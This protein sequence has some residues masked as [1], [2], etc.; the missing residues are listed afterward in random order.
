MAKG[1]ATAFDE[2]QLDANKAVHNLSTAVIKVGFVD[3]TI[4]PAADDPTP[5]WADYS[6][7]EVSTDGGYPA[8]GVILATVTF[9]LINGVP[10]LKADDVEL[11]MDPAGFT[12]AAYG[13]VYNSSAAN[14]EALGAVDFGGD[15]SEQA[16]PVSIE[17]LDGVV[18][19]F[20]ANAAA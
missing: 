14:D 4:V 13:I 19:E 8:G 12:D 16:G 9:T 6:A 1:T 17:W 11:A 15:I 7:N 3:D 10:T 2:Y 5:R 18:A 20:L